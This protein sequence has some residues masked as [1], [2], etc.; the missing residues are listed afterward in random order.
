MGFRM[1]EELPQLDPVLQVRPD[2]D[3]DIP[4]DRDKKEIY[5]PQKRAQSDTDFP[6]IIPEIS[7]C[8][9]YSERFH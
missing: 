6:S 1:E 4:S 9:E 2:A 7:N 3:E 5:G 8:G